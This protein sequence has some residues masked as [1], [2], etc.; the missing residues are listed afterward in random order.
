MSIYCQSE[1]EMPKRKGMTWGQRDL[2]GKRE[3]ER[4]KMQEM[5]EKQNGMRMTGFNDDLFTVNAV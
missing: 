1:R 2:E 5:W 3:Q 4:E